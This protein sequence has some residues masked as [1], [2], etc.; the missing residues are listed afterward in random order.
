MLGKSIPRTSLAWFPFTFPSNSS[1]EVYVPDV[2]APS[3]DGINVNTSST[4]SW[5]EDATKIE[6]QGNSVKRFEK[7]D[8]FDL[9]SLTTSDT[10]AIAVDWPGQFR[11]M[12]TL[13][14]KFLDW[15]NNG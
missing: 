7:P 8:H 2:S 11:L 4:S 15:M 3:C 9:L 10:I 13:Q 12:Q 5:Q 14:R 1:V 6:F